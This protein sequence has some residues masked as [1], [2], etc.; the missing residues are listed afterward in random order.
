MM[1]DSMRGFTVVALVTAVLTATPTVASGQL[2][3]ELRDGRRALSM[4]LL[5]NDG[6]NVG[7][8]LMLTSRTALTL[9]ISGNA[10]LLSDEDAAQESDQFVGQAFLA[11]GFRH[12]MAG[13]GDVASYLAGRALL[14]F[15]TMVRETTDD[16]GETSRTEMSA[17]SAGGAVGF[18]LE[19]FATDA[20]SVRGEVVLDATWTRATADN[21]GLE[22]ET[23]SLRAGL[24]QSALTI[25]ILF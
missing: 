6:A 9:D 13:R 17:P 18:G 21:D 1:L 2:P 23:T 12:Y 15:E 10:A 7:F 24:G 14:G 16:A 8:S 25:S 20:L 22:Q 11:P 3:S 19:W 5:A 4:G